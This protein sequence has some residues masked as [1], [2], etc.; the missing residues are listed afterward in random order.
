MSEDGLLSYY[1]KRAG[2]YERIYQKPER[3]KDL[4]R[5]RD[6]LTSELRSKDVLEVACGTGY[7]TQSVAAVARSVTATDASSEVLDVARQKTYPHERVRFIV[8]DAFDLTNIPGVFTAALAAFWFSH[9]ARRDQSRFLTGLHCKLA[10]GATVTFMDNRYVEGSSTP[11]SRRDADGNT[12]QLRTLRD[13]SAHEVLKN[14]PTASDL[15]PVFEPIAERLT[16]M[17]FDYFWAL[18]YDVPDNTAHRQDG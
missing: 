13:G 16:I 1:R 2:E 11:I 4:A 5:L 9:V 14:F 17:E 15:K 3:Q 6:W 7:W 12:Y 8:A 10:P 18:R